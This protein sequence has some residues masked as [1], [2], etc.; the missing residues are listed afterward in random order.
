MLSKHHDVDAAAI[1]P[2]ITTPLPGLHS[3]IM[4]FR[5]AVI[6]HMLLILWAAM[7][8]TAVWAKVLVSAVTWSSTVCSTRCRHGCCHN[9][10]AWTT[11]VEGT[12]ADSVPTVRTHVSVFTWHCSGLPVRKP[13]QCRQHRHAS[14]PTLSQHVNT[15]GPVDTTLYRWWSSVSGCCVTRLE[16]SSCDCSWRVNTVCILPAV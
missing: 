14:T 5:I 7:A 4:P 9:T 15:A 2:I 10:V 3:S 11:L 16:C 13:T 1:H 12:T 8:L 6:S